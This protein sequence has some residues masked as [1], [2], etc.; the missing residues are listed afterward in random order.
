MVNIWYFAWL[1]LYKK[2]VMYYVSGVI[3]VYHTKMSE[4]FIITTS[5]SRLFY[6]KYNNNFLTPKGKNG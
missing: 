1:S 6:E 3:N 4:T 5:V 2:L